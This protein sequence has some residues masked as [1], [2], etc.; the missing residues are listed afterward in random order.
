LFA[1][2]E[3]MSFTVNLVVVLPSKA[4]Q[5]SDYVE[6]IEYIGQVSLQCHQLFLGL[7]GEEYVKLVAQFK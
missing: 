2:E 7:F 3:I 6:F 4:L 1:S 5:S